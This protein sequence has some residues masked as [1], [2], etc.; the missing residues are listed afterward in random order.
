MVEKDHLLTL[1]RIHF[2]AKEISN[3][4]NFHWLLIV[5]FLGSSVLTQSFSDKVLDFNK[6]EKRGLN[7]YTHEWKVCVLSVS[8]AD[9]KENAKCFLKSVDD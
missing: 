2:W 5:S 8:P 3:A 6:V 4:V 9:V 1:F 7:I